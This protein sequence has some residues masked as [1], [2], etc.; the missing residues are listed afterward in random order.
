MLFTKRDIHRL[1]FPLIVEQLLAVLVGMADVIMVAYVGETAVSAVSIV[2]AITNLI[3]NLFA[4]L[5]TGGAVIC[6][7]SIGRKDRETACYSTNQL[8]LA[9][10][11][12]GIAIMTIALVGNKF[13]LDLLYGSAEADVLATART[14]F[15]Y[16]ALS[17]PFL[18][19]YNASAALF[20][21]AG[22]S[23]I[24][25]RVSLYMNAINI[26][27]NALCIY[28]LKMGVEGVAIPTL[29]ARVFAAIMMFCLLRD[30]Q[31]IVHLMP[32]KKWYA[33]DLPLI[34]RILGIGVP[35]G[36]E[37]GMF[38][39]GRVMMQSLVSTLGTATIAAYAVSNN[40]HTFQY[41]PSNAVCMA[42]M[43][44]AGQCVGAAKYEEGVKNTKYLIRIGY[45]MLILI[46]SLL[47]LLRWPL[48]SIYNLSADGQAIAAELIVVG[49]ITITTI[50]PLAFQLPNAL[51]AASDV[52]TTMTVSII[53]MWIFRIGL[54][55]LLIRFMDLSITYI[56]L[57][58]AVDWIIRAGY[59][60][61]RF[62]ARR[63]R[64]KDLYLAEKRQTKAA[65]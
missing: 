38:Q 16:G 47:V 29:I 36:L 12:M 10:G 4:A 33:F 37:N 26:A 15:F 25:M 5:A 39:L 13:W 57:A 27:G 22:N 9:A 17:Y 32:T 64:P 30:D 18:G 55:Y 2:D 51:R 61:Y 24:S 43:T 11:V 14:Y 50:W 54:A 23:K 60:I 41:Q 59:F 65:G 49:S 52:K 7:Q 34:K 62:S 42:I 45:L 31:N 48:T 53:S 44:V 8:L 3:I 40:L 1:L 56:W 46:S 35:S 28:A 63:L 58:M 6:A 21:A 20:R 19:L